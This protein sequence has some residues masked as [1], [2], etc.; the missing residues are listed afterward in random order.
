M[1]IHMCICRFTCICMAIIRGICVIK[2]KQAGSYADIESNEMIKKKAK[3]AAYI[4]NDDA[5]VG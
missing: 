4:I 3:D 5:I 2:K 1:H